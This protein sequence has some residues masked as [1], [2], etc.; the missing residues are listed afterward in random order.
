MSTRIR[1]NTSSLIVVASS[2]CNARRRAGGTATPT[3]RFDFALLSLL[4]LLLLLMLPLSCPTV[5]YGEVTLECSRGTASQG[6]AVA[7]KELLDDVDDDTDINIF[8]E[9]TCADILS[10][11]SHSAP[12]GTYNI[13]CRCS[14]DEGWE[15]PNCDIQQQCTT[16]NDCHG[17]AINASGNR[18]NC[19]CTCQPEWTGSSCN[20]SNVCTITDDC[21]GWASNVTGNRPN[22]GCT[23]QPEWTGVSCNVS[24]VCT[25]DHDCSGNATG[26]SG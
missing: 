17:G 19:D 12:T 8:D 6:V 21:S 5:A 13:D 7:H 15:G 1:G 14:C 9:R 24:N 25:V 22:C 4:Q 16:V 23:C 18:P 2:F 20:V 26:V 10:C 11:N 3:A